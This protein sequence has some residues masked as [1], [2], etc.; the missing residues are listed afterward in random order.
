MM[1][2]DRRCLVFNEMGLK[3]AGLTVDSMD[4]FFTLPAIKSEDGSKEENGQLE[5]ALDT[6]S[7]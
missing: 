6:K 1:V 5:T 2:D 4:F 3:L 7:K